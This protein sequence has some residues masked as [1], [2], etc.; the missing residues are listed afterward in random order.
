VRIALR[1]LGLVLLLLSA[2]CLVLV[3][4]P[5]PRAVAEFMGASCAYGQFDDPEQC[6]G[7]DAVSLLWSGVWIFAILGLVLRLTTRPAG[8]GPRTLDLR[9]LRG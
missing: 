9:R 7:W 3:F 4:V 1:V 5:G 2:T 8:R 6:T